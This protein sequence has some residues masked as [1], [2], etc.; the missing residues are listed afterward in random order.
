MNVREIEHYLR[1]VGQMSGSV[2]KQSANIL[3]KSFNQGLE[4]QR[5]VVNSINALIETIKH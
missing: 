4:E 5:D 2:A 3:Y 1:D